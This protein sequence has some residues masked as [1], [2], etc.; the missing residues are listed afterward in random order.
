MRF[1]NYVTTI[2]LSFSLVAC[3]GG[4]SATQST[5]V[6]QTY[7]IPAPGATFSGIWFPVDETSSTYAGELASV[8]SSI[9]KIGSTERYGVVLSGWG[10]QSWNSN[11]W[12]SSTDAPKVN[13]G[14]LAPDSNGNLNIATSNYIENTTTNG[15]GSVIVTDI[16][17]DNISDVVLISHNE[18]PI[19]ANNSTVYYGSSNGKFTK[20]TLTDNLAA[21]DSQLYTINGKKYI[22]PGVVTG[23]P[24]VAYYEFTNNAISPVYTNNISYYNSDYLLYGNMSQAVVKNKNN[25]HALVTSG[26]CADS[27]HTASE[28][29][30][31]SYFSM[32]V[33]NFVSGDIQRT[34]KQR[35]KPYLTDH[36]LYSKL[37][38]EIGTNETHVYR[39]WADDLNQDGNDDIIAAQSMWLA[40]SEL[41]PTALQVLINNGNNTFTDKTESLNPEMLHSSN[42]KLTLDMNPTF[43]DIDNSGI[44]TYFFGSF[45]FSNPGTQYQSNYVVL[46]D[47]TGRLY[48]GLNK[49]FEEYAMQVHDI[50]KEK[51]YSYDTTHIPK[52]VAVPQTNGTLNFLAISPVNAVNPKT[53]KSQ[54][55]YAMVNI[56]A[57]YSPATDFKTNIIITDRNKSLN[58]RTWAGDDTIHDTNAQLGTRING[59]LGKNKM[60]YSGPSSQYTITKNTDNS[61]RVTSPGGTGYPAIDDTLKNVYTIQF[62]DIT[63]ELK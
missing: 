22:F 14:L 40:K 26:G 19:V 49:K 17:N 2:V 39:V 38:S 36:T 6:A 12:Q 44:K 43:L 33:F 9:I 3:G 51:G 28:C 37:A 29:L 41:F 58:I 54:Q 25:E 42:P 8:F 61:F 48:V 20:Q 13:I 50:L 24:R 53:G 56:P 31:H 4:G 60:V 52:F 46:N 62:A 10:Y 21:H 47:G 15:S 35:I 23:H 57:N 1:P 55:G 59:G 7:A 34:P 32:N 27:W 45:A 30:A 18:T 16:N 63:K 5:N 11:Q